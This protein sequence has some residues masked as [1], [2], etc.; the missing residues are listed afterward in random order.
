MF[1]VDV[2]ADVFPVPTNTPP[3]GNMMSVVVLRQFY[4]ARFQFFIIGW[5]GRRDALRGT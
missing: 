1:H 2:V 3:I 5:V 4:S